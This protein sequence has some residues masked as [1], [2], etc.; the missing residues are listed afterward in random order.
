MIGMNTHE[1][2]AALQKAGANPMTY[3]IYCEPPLDGPLP[4]AGG[5]GSGA[6][7]L[8]RQPDGRWEQGYYERGEW[9]PER[10]FDSEDEACRHTLATVLKVARPSS[11]A[12]N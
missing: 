7:Y 11:A 3:A 6:I 9:T 10:F 1:L 8:C 2:V 5:L 4:Y 12:S